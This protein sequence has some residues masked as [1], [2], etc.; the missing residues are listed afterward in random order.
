[1]SYIVAQSEGVSKF[2][3]GRCY[4][5]PQKDEW[6]SFCASTIERRYYRALR[7]ADPVGALERKVREDAGTAQAM[8]DGLLEALRSRQ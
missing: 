3:F 7:S 1:V 2:I 4:R 6:V 8:S 5:H